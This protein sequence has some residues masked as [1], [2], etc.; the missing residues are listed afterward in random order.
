ML[1]EVYICINVEFEGTGLQNTV[2][3]YVMYNPV[4]VI[5]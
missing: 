2:A 5:Y 1:Y 4:S 3:K